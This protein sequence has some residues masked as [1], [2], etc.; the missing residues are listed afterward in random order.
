MVKVVEAKKVQGTRLPSEVCPGTFGAVLGRGGFGTVYECLTDAGGLVA[1]KRISLRNLPKE[2]L[3][4]IEQE[5][6]LLKKLS[7]P[8]IVSYIDTVRTKEHLSIVLE[9][10]ENGSLTQNIKK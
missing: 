10:M 3:E 7:H 4:T 9:Y 8:N 2:Q 1:V 6:F 5:I